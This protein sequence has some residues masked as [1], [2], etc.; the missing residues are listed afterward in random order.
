MTNP[1]KASLKYWQAV[2]KEEQQNTSKIE[3]FFARKL[4]V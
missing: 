4:D 1:L 2:P 3:N